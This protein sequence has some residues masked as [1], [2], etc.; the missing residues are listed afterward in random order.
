MYL[1]PAVRRALPPP[2]GCLSRVGLSL[3]HTL[4]ELKAGPASGNACA[5]EVC[6]RE[7]E[8]CQ[9]QG[10]E[11]CFID[12]IYDAV[13]PPGQC[14]ALHRPLPCNHHHRTHATTTTALTPPIRYIAHVV[15]QTSSPSSPSSPPFN[16]QS[17]F[18][19]ANE[20]PDSPSPPPL[21]ISNPSVGDDYHMHWCGLPCKA[22]AFLAFE[23]M[24]QVQHWHVGAQQ[25]AG[26]HRPQ[27]A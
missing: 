13:L 2:E 22:S 8:S 11:S 15:V 20:N 16:F 5:R 9:A 23:C 14:A 24:V 10:Q 3:A 25:L 27:A 17:K 19:V 6:L 1:S 26:R 4:A 12:V 21:S 18:S 7:D